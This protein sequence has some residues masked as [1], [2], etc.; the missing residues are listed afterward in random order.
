MKNMKMT[1]ETFAALPSRIELSIKYGTS[2]AQNS[3]GYNTVTLLG[4]RG[5]IGKYKEC[6]G[7]YDQVGAAIGQ[8]IKDQFKKALLEVTDQCSNFYGFYYNESHTLRVDGACGLSSMEKI[9]T[10]L[11]GYNISYE[12]KRDR[13]GRPQHKTAVILIKKIIP[14]NVR[15]LTEDQVLT[16]PVFNISQEYKYISEI[17]PTEYL[18]SENIGYYIRKNPTAKYIALRAHSNQWYLLNV[19]KQVVKDSLKSS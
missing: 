3:Y 6:G 1:A 9:L 8:F 13:K 17:N 19:K 16:K 7:G 15:L 14:S 12:Y 18:T 2:R 5:N 11:L 4:V 10:E